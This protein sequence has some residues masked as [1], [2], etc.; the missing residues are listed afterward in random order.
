M[1]YTDIQIEAIKI[2]WRKDL[3]VGCLIRSKNDFQ[4]EWN[5]YHKWTITMI[6]VWNRTWDDF[7][8]NTEIEVLWHQP[9]IEDI[10]IECHNKWIVCE[11]YISNISKWYKIFFEKEW[12]LES[13]EYNQW[14][15]LLEQ[16]YLSDII[17]LFKKYD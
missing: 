10:F 14:L 13:V 1:R 9:H 16:P 3:T 6:W 4:T 5:Y 15:Y 12:D 7:F 2:F 8:W 11:C 17:S